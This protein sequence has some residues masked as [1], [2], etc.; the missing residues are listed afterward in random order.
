MLPATIIVLAAAWTLWVIL[1][2]KRNLAAP[3]AVE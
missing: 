2:E 3:P 1:G